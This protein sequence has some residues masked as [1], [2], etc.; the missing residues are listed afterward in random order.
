M[1]EFKQLLK[2]TVVFVVA[3]GTGAGIYGAGALAANG[4]IASSSPSEKQAI[5][6]QAVKKNLLL[7]S[8]C[9]PC[10]PKKNLCNPCAAKNPCNPCASAK[11]ETQSGCVVPEL[12]AA[13]PCAAKNPCNPCAAKN[14][15]NPC[16][17]KNPC[18]PCA[19]KNPCNPCGAADVAEL[20]PQQAI[21]A[22]DCIQSEL[23]SSY[24][25]AGLSEVQNYIGWENVALSPYQ[26]VTHGNR[27]VNNW[28]N[29]VGAAQYRKYE[30]A[31]Q[32]PVGSVIVKDSFEVTASGA[33]SPGP[34]FIMEKMADGFQPELGNW[35][36]SMV[37]PD[38]SIFGQTKGKNTAG[39]VFCSECHASAEDQDYLLFLPEELR[40]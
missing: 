37:M 12:A 39:M 29:T 19:A 16:A 22:Y 31:G 1:Q 9:N 24:A 13:N 4:E 25:K 32:M 34:M 5:N 36:Y 26:A 28:V 23:I 18:N 3:V 17:A 35:K 11:V 40:K 2:S 27:Y 15:C 6:P 14:P 21:A 33:I 10:N 30:D 20:S 38:G 7:A 8:T